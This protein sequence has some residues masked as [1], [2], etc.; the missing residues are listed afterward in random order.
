MSWQCLILLKVALQMRTSTTPE[1]EWPPQAPCAEWR[2]PAPATRGLDRPFTAPTPHS[3]SCGVAV[4]QGDPSP[5]MLSPGPPVSEQ[6]LQNQL[7]AWGRRNSTIG[8]Q[9]GRCIWGP[10]KGSQG[11]P[12]STGRAALGT[13][14]GLGLAGF[15]FPDGS[16]SKQRSHSGL[17][18]PGETGPP[19]T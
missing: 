6:R 14:G 3:L 2:Q 4:L 13:R 15:V 18:K 1:A 17:P 16:I 11:R 8:H 12:P 9:P 19:K 5:A 7:I 10:R